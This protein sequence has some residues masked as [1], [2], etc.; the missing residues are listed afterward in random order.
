VQPKESEEVRRDVVSRALLKAAELIGGLTAL[1]VYLDVDR[2]ELFGWI[3][4]KG[5]PPEDTFVRVV[6]ILIDPLA[7]QDAAI[8]H[9]RLG[10]ESGPSDEKSLPE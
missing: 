3:V 8:T 6:E 5:T 4:G 9:G 10:E 1:Q 7:A 2:A